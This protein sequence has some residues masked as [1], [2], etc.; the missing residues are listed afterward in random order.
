MLQKYNGM[1]SV[2]LEIKRE[3]HS[4]IFQIKLLMFKEKAYLR[5]QSYK[6]NVIAWKG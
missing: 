5:V 6:I 1:H 3:D 4:H 2:H